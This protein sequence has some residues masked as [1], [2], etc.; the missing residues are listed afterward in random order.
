MRP[1]HRYINGVKNTI[2]GVEAQ[3]QSIWIQAGQR[4]LLDCDIDVYMLIVQ[5]T[6]EFDRTDI[7]LTANYIFIMHGT[8]AVGS[9]L[10]PFLHQATIT[11]RGSPI[12]QEIPV[13]GAKTLS[14]RFCTLD[15]H[16]APVLDGRTHTKLA[17]TAPIG[18]SEVLLAPS[19]PLPLPLLS[20]PPLP[21]PYPCRP[22]ELPPSE[23]EP[24]AAC[25]STNCRWCSPSGWTGPSPQRFSLRAR[26]PAAVWKTMRLRTSLT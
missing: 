16:G 26:A 13:Y 7:N 2:P 3:G 10:E 24:P 22:L 1:A 19:S 5:G 9:E 21:P 20:S 4:L 18:A 6:L 25:L 12:S 17:Q 14:C 15:L 8:F 11:L 23:A